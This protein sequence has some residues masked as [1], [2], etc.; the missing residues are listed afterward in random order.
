MT[1]EKCRQML[2]NAGEGSSDGALS[3]CMMSDGRI[4][5]EVDIDMGARNRRAWRL[6]AAPVLP[7][8]CPVSTGK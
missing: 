5:D 8:P 3:V 7:W 6:A 4:E 2:Y 1:L